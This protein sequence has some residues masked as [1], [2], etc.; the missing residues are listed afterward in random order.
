MAIKL[1]QPIQD[2][3]KN[4]KNNENGSCVWGV[5]KPQSESSCTTGYTEIAGAT[6]REMRV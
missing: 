5:S 3:C 4:C 2:I 1:E 6:F